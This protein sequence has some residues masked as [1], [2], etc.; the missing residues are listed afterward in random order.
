MHM[1][2]QPR[3]TG[4]ECEQPVV[5]FDT[6]D[7]RQTQPFQIG[8]ELQNAFDQQSEIVL[9]GQVGAI[10]GNIHTGQHDFL[11]AFIDQ[12][13]DMFDHTSG[14]DRTAVA[15]SEGN[16]AEGAPVVTAILHLNKGARFSGIG[17]HQMRRRLL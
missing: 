10:A 4:Q 7:R 6:V 12:H 9:A 17:C 14:W 13:P 5:N 15:A 11:E 8:H 1:R 16:D 3:L 2:H